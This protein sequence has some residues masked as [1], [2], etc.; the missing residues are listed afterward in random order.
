MFRVLN[1]PTKPQILTDWELYYIY[2]YYIIYV[3]VCVCVSISIAQ[4][5]VHVRN[6]VNLY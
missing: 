5:Q 2:T 6:P 4:Y 3:C 1:H